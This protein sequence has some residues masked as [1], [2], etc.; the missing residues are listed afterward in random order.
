MIRFRPVLLTSLTT[1]GGLFFLAFLAKGQAQFLSPMAVSI[2]FGLMMA[3]IITLLVVPAM[4]SVTDD[5]ALH[6]RRRR[7]GTV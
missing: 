5:I 3:T 7:K 1:I 2:F 6:F 4:Y